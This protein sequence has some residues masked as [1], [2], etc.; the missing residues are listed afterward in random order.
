MGYCLWY[1]LTV[2]NCSNDTKDKEP[3]EHISSVAQQQDKEQT[4]HHGYHQ[5]T[6][7]TQTRVAKRVAKRFIYTLII[8][9]N[10]SGAI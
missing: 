9:L 5:T 4:D 1:I 10:L 7:T 8:N 6:A 3:Q 2:A